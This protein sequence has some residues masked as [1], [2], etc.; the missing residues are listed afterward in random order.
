MTFL[1]KHRDA[2]RIHG[3]VMLHLSTIEKLGYPKDSCLAHACVHWSIRSS[4][5]WP[6]RI[7]DAAVAFLDSRDKYVEFHDLLI[8]GAS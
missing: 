7:M 3:E 8:E 5:A 2:C 6:N 4:R 1:K